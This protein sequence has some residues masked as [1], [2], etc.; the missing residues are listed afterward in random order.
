MVEI[1][2][3]A[4][5][6]AQYIALTSEGIENLLFE[7][8]R[9]LG[10][11]EVKQSVHSVS[12]TADLQ[13][14]CNICLWTRFSSRV[15]QKI[16][17]FEV[18]KTEDLYNAAK[19]IPWKDHL[20]VSQTFAIDFVGTNEFINNTQFGGM[21]VKDAMADYF[22]D[23][24]GERP[25]VDKYQPN[26]CVQVRLRNTSAT[27]Y[28]DFSGSSLHKRGYRQEQG[29][30]PLKEN[31][32][33]AI[34]TRSG[35][36]KDTTKPLLD[37]FCGSGTL[38]I[39][40]VMMATKM[41]P[42]LWREQF[43]FERYKHFDAA[44]FSAQLKT[45]RAAEITV[46]GLN[47]MGSDVDQRIVLTARA[48]AKL[49]EV[50][51]LIQFSKTDA[52]KLVKSQ[53]DD[54][55]IVSNPPY[56]ERMGESTEIAYLYAAFGTALKQHFCGWKMAFFT[57]D[58][59]PARQLRLAKKKAYKFKNGPLNCL[60]Y[61]YD[62]TPR[63]CEINDQKNSEA[64]VM[65]NFTES[66]SFAN[67]LK[68]ND[69]LFRPQA[70]R[71][72]VN[73]YRI[74]DADIPEYNVAIDRYDDKVVVHEYAAP[75]TVDENIAKQRLA[76]IMLATPTVLGVNSKDIA[77]K[78]REKQKGT[79]QYQAMD[80]V[81]DTFVVQEYG[82]NLSVNLFDYLDTGVFLDHRLTRQKIGQL[83]P[84]K[85]VLNLFAYTGTASVHAALGGAN[86]VTTV[87]MSK[88]YLDWAKRNFELNGLKGEQYQFVQADCMN[89][90]KEGDDQFDVIFIDPPTFSNS[91]RMEDTFDVLR[92]HKDLL[93]SLKPRLN[94][95]G[96]IVFSNNHR[97][98]KMDEAGLAAEGFE[99]ENITAQ[100]IPFDFK[101]NPK[102]HNCWLLKLS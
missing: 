5:D 72:N 17:T 63:Q 37:P 40:A 58:D 21:K 29:M 51:A 14:A 49:A 76:D 19:S 68:K 7:E 85:S 50:E 25:S 43:A 30:A 44:A 22:V 100:T 26:V 54:G 39:E 3:M 66:E 69:K 46:E 42:G 71:E 61:I 99:I 33:A 35:W 23:N 15:L 101:R 13:T 20:D 6:M 60:L 96:V 4:Q 80:K 65:F 87:D 89:W 98:F 82:I 9:Q 67:R 18:E 10:A 59:A 55:F 83:S 31:L 62:L 11:T 79:K 77:L 45:A 90:I 64:A 57:Q 32:A 27:F 48:N 70:K 94:D 1:E 75:K 95:G 92:D 102:I 74:Y 41:A 78:V 36:L 56:G 52:T 73:C 93:M 88:T 12:F 2:F 53:K 97:R 34:I 8:L 86:A 47:V 28:L 91:K 81:N 38:L 16:N 84:G 24:F